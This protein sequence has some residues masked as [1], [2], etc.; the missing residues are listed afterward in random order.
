MPTRMQLVKAKSGTLALLAALMVLSLACHWS[1]SG[2]SQ[3]KP[4]TAV[5]PVNPAAASSKP[6]LIVSGLSPA[7]FTD[8]DFQRHVEQLDLRLKKKLAM[9]GTRPH[10]FF[11]VIQKPFVVVGDESQKAV[12]ERATNTVKWAVDHLKRD[13]FLKDPE[14]ILEIWL[15]K[16]EAS[17]N[18]HTLLLFGDTP[19]T[20]FGYYSPSHK[21]LIMNIGTGGG[22]LV[23]EIVHPFVE[24]NF[25]ACPAWLNEGLGSLY[26]QCGEEDGRI[27]GY[28]NWR[29]PG[30]QRAIR[31]GAV[32]SFKT[33][34]SL[35]SSAF[36]NQ[37]KGT[38]YAQS[39]YLLYYLQ[40]KGLLVKFYKEF[41]ARQKEDPTGFDS[42]QKILGEADM[43]IFKEN[44]EQYVLKLRQ[45]YEVTVQ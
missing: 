1:S 6:A 2:S 34:T 24:A 15:F 26:E 18:K 21:A 11:T 12:Q 33:L 27:H 30:L 31:A 17:Y 5:R 41:Y 9:T 10:G 7:A 37:D 43:D 39:R 25:P 32:P 4:T 14:A 16:D 19:T 3:A 13:Y 42:L 20:P 29:L 35:S 38:N 44:W 36:Y 8:A 40:Q 45:G 23:H 28:T 22:T